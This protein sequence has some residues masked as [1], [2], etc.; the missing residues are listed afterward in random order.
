MNSDLLDLP[1]FC[2]SRPA[3]LAGEDADAFWTFHR[4]NPAVYRLLVRLAREWHRAT[5]KKIG[6]KCLFERARWEH[7]MTTTGEEYVLNNNHTPYYARLIMHQER[8]LDGL[9]NRRE[10]R[11][12]A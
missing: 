12:A 3:F 4:A 2:P 7:A 10:Q 1:L 5:R 9:F 11:G 6:M 8:D